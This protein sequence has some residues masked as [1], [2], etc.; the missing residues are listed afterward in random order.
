[1]IFVVAGILGV[2]TSSIV[3]MVGSA[4]LAIGLALQ[5]SLANLAGGVLILLLKPFQVEIILLRHN[6]R[7]P[8]RV[9]IFLHAIDD[10]G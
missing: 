1:M 9:L 7:E 10:N 8:Y 4:G 3:A 6:R 2:G 5:G